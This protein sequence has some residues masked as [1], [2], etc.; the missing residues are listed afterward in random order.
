MTDPGPA[1]YDVTERGRA[2]LARYR[3]DQLVT[4]EPARQLDLFE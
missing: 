2:F 1:A 4:D 3:A